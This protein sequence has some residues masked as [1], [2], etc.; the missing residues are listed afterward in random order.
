MADCG[1]ALRVAN[2]IDKSLHRKN[3]S[4]PRV[5]AALGTARAWLDGHDLPR[6]ADSAL[7]A[8]CSHRRRV[9]SR[10]DACSCLE[11]KNIRTIYSFGDC[12][13]RDTAQRLGQLLN[14]GHPRWDLGA[15]DNRAA[16]ARAS[17]PRFARRRAG[18]A[19]CTRR[20]TAFTPTTASTG[21]RRSWCSGSC[22]RREVSSSR[23]GGGRGENVLQFLGAPKTVGSH[24]LAAL[25]S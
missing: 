8:A 24:D 13:A 12:I 3:A 9:F 14:E 2:A 4:S 20:S 22:A 15:G 21:R 1:D 10:A 25:T 11:R 6:A 17:S 23:P 7:P 19:S 16:A 18:L 5:I